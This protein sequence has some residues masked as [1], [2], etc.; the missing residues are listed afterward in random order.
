MSTTYPTNK[1]DRARFAALT[2]EQQEQVS[3]RSDELYD[4]T[5]TVAKAFTTAL[6]EHAAE[7]LDRIRGLLCESDQGCNARALLSSLLCADHVL[8]AATR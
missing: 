3:T 1:R 7:N 4:G 2:A 5:R 8:A 6:D